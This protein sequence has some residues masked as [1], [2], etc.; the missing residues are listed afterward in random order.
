L[1]VKFELRRFTVS[2]V[3][4]LIVPT[5]ESVFVELRTLVSWTVVV[6]PSS[7]TSMKLP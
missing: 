6:D 1:A 4:S 2:G 3:S 5:P 7:Q